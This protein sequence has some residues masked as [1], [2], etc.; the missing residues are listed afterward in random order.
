MKRRW[1]KVD[2]EEICKGQKRTEE[3]RIEGMKERREDGSKGGRKEGRKKARKEG[4]KEIR[5]GRKSEYKKEE[6]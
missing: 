4:W 1:N 2:A 5:E 6:E 3:K